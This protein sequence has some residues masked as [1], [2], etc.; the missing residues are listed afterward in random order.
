MSIRKPRSI[1]QTQHE[2]WI[3]PNRGNCRMRLLQLPTWMLSKAASSSKAITI[4]CG[5]SSSRMIAIRS[6]WRRRC[7]WPV[8]RTCRSLAQERVR[9]AYAQLDGAKVLWVPNISG[10]IGFND[11]AGQLQNIEG[12]IL[13]KST[14]SRCLWVAVRLQF[15]AGRWRR[16][17]RRG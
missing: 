14:V 1:R 2:Q 12:Q 4:L 16:T 6:R 10:G 5:R 13:E 7:T 9:E 3:G 8:E 11:H 15:A 17:R